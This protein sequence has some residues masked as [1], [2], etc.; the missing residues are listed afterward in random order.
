MKRE[1]MLKNDLLWR[2][3]NKRKNTPTEKT[4]N[5]DLPPMETISILI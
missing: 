3:K 4:Y 5:V 2:K 1:Q